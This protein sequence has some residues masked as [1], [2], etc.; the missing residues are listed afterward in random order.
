MS[1]V[2]SKH[3]SDL[4]F[5]PNDQALPSYKE[6]WKKLDDDGQREWYLGE[7]RSRLAAKVTQN[8]VIGWLNSEGLDSA[9]ITWLMVWAETDSPPPIAST[10]LHV[11]YSLDAEVHSHSLPFSYKPGFPTVHTDPVESCRSRASKGVADEA[12]HDAPAPEFR[13]AKPSDA[14]ESWLSQH[15][16]DMGNVIR[17]MILIIAIVIILLLGLIVMM[18]C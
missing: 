3:W 1:N 7:I 10:S 17:G 12:V 15:A 11:G 4:N 5:A 9:T 8:E 6:H 13:F 14:N 2:K 18:F 16:Y